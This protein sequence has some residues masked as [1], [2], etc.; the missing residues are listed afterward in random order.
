VIAAIA[1]A[2]CAPPPPPLPA[3]LPAPPSPALSEEDVKPVEKPRI[4][5]ADLNETPSTDRKA[6]TL[7]G[8]LVNRGTRATREISVH[9]EA[10]N[11]DGAV[12]LSAD[13]D[14]STETIVPGGIGRFAVTFAN[15]ADIDHYRVEAISR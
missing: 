1:V 8:T 12:V 11:K 15:R 13:S 3:V 14:P 10:L 7:T 2:G 4:A 5:I 6:V 9:V